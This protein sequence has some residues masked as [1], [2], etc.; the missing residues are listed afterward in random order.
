MNTSRRNSIFITMT[1]FVVIFYGGMFAMH[2]MSAPVPVE[3]SA[4]SEKRLSH[5]ALEERERVFLE[6]LKSHPRL[7]GSFTLV[8]LVLMA[9]GLALD[10]FFVVARFSGRPALRRVAD[11]GSVPW[12]FLDLV[13]ALVFFLFLEAIFFFI[14]GLLSFLTTLEM[15]SDRI[16]MFNSLLR[17]AALAFFILWLIRS[18]HDRPLSDIGLMGSG[19]KS[20]ARTGVVAYV[21]ILPALILA[22][23]FAAATAKFFSYEPM[24]Q[25][26]VQVYLG[27]SAG[28]PLLFFTFFVAVAG[29]IVE[30][31]LFRGFAYKALRTRL[32]VPWAIV[33][34]SLLFT[35]LHVNL[36]ASIPIFLLGVFLAYLYEK[37]GSLVA[38]I[39][40]HVTHNLIMVG[41]TLFFKS[42]SAGA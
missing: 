24:P 36:L 9:M 40:A 2:R 20:A 32:G 16:L 19:W 33:L 10:T 42:F 11:H 25:T 35:M 34:S 21:A 1:L 17:D 15:H 26:V 12:G 39:T 18:R 5:E 3:D 31:M 28:G 29:P 37:T 22:L 38:P 13:W 14:G 4:V 6:R 30:E 41:L 7:I 8:F 27:E 23:L